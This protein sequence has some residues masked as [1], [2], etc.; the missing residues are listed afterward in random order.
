MFSMKRSPSLPRISSRFSRGARQRAPSPM[1]VPAAP[2]PVAPPRVV[3]ATAAQRPIHE[4]YMDGS[5]YDGQ[6]DDGERHG[7]GVWK[8]HDQSYE[9]EW[10]R[11]A[12]HGRGKQSWTDGRLYEGQFRMGK[13]HGFGRMEWITPEGPMAY[14]G[15]YRN[16]L[17]HGEGRYA[18]PNG[19]MYNGQ[20]V[21]GARH[22]SA[23]VTNSHGDSR[24]GV[25]NADRLE[26][27]VGVPAG[28][29]TAGLAPVLMDLSMEVMAVASDDI[30]TDVCT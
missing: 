11:D 12:R 24:Q 16:D 29:C 28:S 5:A 15:Q 20:W 4:D 22:G 8:S 27:W 13:F 26:T 6:L 30:Y 3:E 7:K 9:G 25:W 2:T 23:T 18:W 10:F 19:C 17:K 21:D 1:P 14:E